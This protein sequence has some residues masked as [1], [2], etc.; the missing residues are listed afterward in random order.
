M[1]KNKSS[2]AIYSTFVNVIPV[3]VVSLDKDCCC[4]L[5]KLSHGNKYEYESNKN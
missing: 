3:N 5:D 1:F 4:Q 2:C